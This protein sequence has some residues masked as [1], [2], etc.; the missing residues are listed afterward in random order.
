MITLITVTLLATAI[1]Y[2]NWDM[3]T[4]IIEDKFDFELGSLS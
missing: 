1:S 2:L 3:V 4:I